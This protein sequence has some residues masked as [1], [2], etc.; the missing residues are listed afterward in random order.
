MKKKKAVA[1]NPAGV[2][3]HLPE[4]R[5]LTIPQ[6]AAYIGARPFFVRTL[7]WQQ[8]RTG[9]GGIPYIILGKRIVIDKSDLDKYIES[10]KAAA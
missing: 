8:R 3:P 5:M 7:C 2:D 10:Q 9:K 4:S 1:T 6:A